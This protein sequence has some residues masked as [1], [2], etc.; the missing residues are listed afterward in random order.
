MLSWAEP[1]SPSLASFVLWIYLV[2]AP[3]LNGTLTPPGPGEQLGGRCPQYFEI[4]VGWHRS[5]STVVID[6]Q[7]KPFTIYGWNIC[8]GCGMNLKMWKPHLAI[9]GVLSTYGVAVAP[10][11]WIRLDF[12]PQFQPEARRT[13][14]VGGTGCSPV[15]TW[16][17]RPQTTVGSGQTPAHPT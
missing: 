8:K 7:V 15:H 16:R 12:M 2:G 4:S 14:S 11:I 9:A 5:I 10:H 1:I 6:E 3:A 17:K 13:G